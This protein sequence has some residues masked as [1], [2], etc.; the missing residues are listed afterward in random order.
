MCSAVDLDLPAKALHGVVCDE[1]T[2]PQ[3]FVLASLPVIS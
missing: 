3:T 1:E 2:Q